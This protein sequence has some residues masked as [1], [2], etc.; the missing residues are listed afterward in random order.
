MT[1][2]ILE[3]VNQLTNCF[4]IFTQNYTLNSKQLR[5]IICVFHD[6]IVIL[7]HDSIVILNHDSNVILNHDSNEN[8]LLDIYENLIN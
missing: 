7:N 6:S 5:R 8:N 3:Q 2:F 4:I 1:I